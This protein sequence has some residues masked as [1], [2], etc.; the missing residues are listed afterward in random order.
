MI[1]SLTGGSSAIFAHALSVMGEQDE[2]IAVSQ[3]SDATGEWYPIRLS[4]HD[5]RGPDTRL[6][7]VRRLARWL[8]HVRSYG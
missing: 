8:L 7:Q 1:G 4:P 3:T 2:C 5:H 6:S